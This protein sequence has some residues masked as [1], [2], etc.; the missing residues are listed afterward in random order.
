M[1]ESGPSC[2]ENRGESSRQYSLTWWQQ[3]SHLTSVSEAVNTAPHVQLVLQV[4]VKS[5]E[6][7]KVAWY[8]KSELA[9]WSP[10]YLSNWTPFSCSQQDAIHSIFQF[11]H[12]RNK[13][14][15]D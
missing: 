12:L 1:A 15:L 10:L 5:A 11:A 13:R 9:S 7:V 6:S 8:K 4:Q 14:S 2:S 3:Q